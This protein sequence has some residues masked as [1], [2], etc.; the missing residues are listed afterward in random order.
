MHIIVFFLI[1]FYWNIVALQC[2][3]SFYVQQS[4]STIC[5]YIYPLVPGFPPHLGLQRAL[6]R[7][8]PLSSHS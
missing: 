6:R 3:I 2:R 5:V 8:Y 7:V 1:N 4:E